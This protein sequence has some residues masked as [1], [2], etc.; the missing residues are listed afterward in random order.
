MRLPETMLRRTTSLSGSLNLHLR[1]TLSSDRTY[2]IN[3]IE[4]D[5]VGKRVLGPRCSTGTWGLQSLYE[6]VDPGIDYCIS[7][8]NSQFTRRSLRR[9]TVGRMIWK[10]TRRAIGHSVLR[11]LFHSLRSSW[12]RGS[13]LWIACVDI[14]FCGRE[15]IEIDII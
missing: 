13:G 5:D 8:Q 6:R 14:I 15:G 11:S 9:C 3:Y 10:L 12:G 7:F 1:I 4:L 2:A